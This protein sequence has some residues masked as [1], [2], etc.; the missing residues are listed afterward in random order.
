MAAL[1]HP[2]SRR[3]YSWWWDSHISPKN[4]KW[5]QENL[6]DMD[7][8]VKQMI[9]LLEEDADS[10]ARRAEMYY[11]KRPELMKLV[12][13]FYRA[14]RALAERYDHATG[15]LRQAHRT[16]AEAFP[17]QVPF[18]DSP[19]GSSASENDPQTPEMSPMIR[20]IFYPDE[21]QKDAL[22]LSPSAFNVFK[23]N[24]AF[25]EE[26]TVT[27]RK[28]LKEPN[29]SFGEGKARKG[30]NF[31]DEEEKEQSTQNNGSEHISA[32]VLSQSEQLGK[33]ETE[34]LTLKETLAKFEAEKEA[35]LLQYQQSLE[36]SS[37]LE[38]EVSSAHKDSKGFSQRASQAEAEVQTLKEAL[39]KLQSERDASVLQYQQCMEMISKL[40]DEV[41]HARKDAGELN[42]RATKTEVEAKAIRQDL[43]TVEAE[44]EAAHAQYNQ[45]LE[46]ISN[47]EEKLLHAEENARM[48]SERAD[49]A[50]TKVEILRQELARLTEEKEAAALQYL[51]CLETIAD[52]KHKISY[53]QEEA[54]RLT[55]E[56]DDGVVKLKGAEERCFLLEKSN[57]TLQSELESLVE[58]M[59][60]QSEELTEKQKELG[61]LWSCIQEERLRFVEAETAFQT[62]QHLHAESQEELR[63][64]GEELQNRTQIL[65]EME[66]CNQ[67]LEDEVQRAKEENKSLNELNLSSVVSIKN[68]QDEILSLRETIRK[69]EE[70]VE[71]R[72]DQRNA[73]QQEIY[74]LREELN[75]LN[76]KHLTVMDQ[77]ESVGYDSECFGSSVKDLQVEN[78]KLKEMCEAESSDKVLLLEKL[79]IVEK[80]LEK[81]VVL[82]NSLSDLHVELEGVKEKVKTLEESCQTLLG[83]KSA[84]VDEKATLIS[85]LQSTAANLE[86]LS[87]KNNFLENSLFD[88]N[89]E[90]EVLRIKSESLED[91]YMLL[92]M[93]KSG[94]V[95]ERESLFSQL[96][97]T[98]QR[99]EDLEKSFS[100]L[101]HKHSDLE[102][103]REC[104]LRKVEELQASL[105]AAQQEHASFSS[106]SEKRLASM[107]L[108]IHVLEEEGQCRKKEYEEQ[109]DK[110]FSAQIEIFILQKSVHDLEKKIVS[111]LIEC[112]NLLEASKLSGKLIS[113]LEH[114]NLEQQVKLKSLFGQM[115]NLRMGLYQV[116]KTL[117]I[118]ADH[119]FENKI[120][121]DEALLRHILSKLQETQNSI[122]RSYD[123]NQQLL[124][125]KSVL[126]TLLGQLKVDAVNVVTE[127]DNLAGEFKIRSE[128]FS[129]LQMEIQNLLGMNEKWRLK[130]MEGD[131]RIEELI[132][133]TENMRGQLMDLQRANQNLQEDYFKVLGEKKSVMKEAFDLVGE[134]SD[135]E[136]ANWVLFGEIMSQCNIS[137]IFNNMVTEKFA[138]LKELT[139]EL[140]K[141]RC[142]NNDLEEKERLMVGKLEDVQTE[143]LNLK[144]SLN[145]SE[146]EFASLKSISDQLRFEIA[147]G[148]DL[149]SRKENELL[150]AEQ[151]FGAT[152]NE[153]RQLH[154]LVEDLKDKY[155]EAKL[156]IKDQEKQILKLSANNDDQSKE[157][158]C[159]REVNQKL[160]SDLCRLCEEL[161]SATIR[162]ESLNSEMRKGTEEIKLWESQ[163]AAFFAELQISNVREVLFEGRIHDLAIACESLENRSNCK[164]TEIV[165]L[166]ERVSTLEGEKEGLEESLN[167]EMQKGTEEIKLWES[168][169]ATFLAELQISSVREVLFEGRIH[170]LAIACESLENRSNCKDTEIELL[171]DRVSTLEG[172]KEGLE[173]SFN[174][175]MRKGIEE[176][177]LWEGQAAAFFAELQISSVGEVLFEGRIH[178][179]TIAFES[180]ENWSNC[181][182]REIELLK[183]RVSTLEGEKEGLEESLNSEMRK[184]TEEIKLWESQAAAF[185]SELQISSV[186]EVLFEGRIHELTIACEGLENRSNCKDREIELLKERVSTLEGEKEG[187]E[188]SLNSEMRKGTEE[189]KLWESHAAA[190]FSEL[191]I[192]SVREVLFEGRI[193]ELT[194]ACEGLENRSNCKDT[195]IELLKEGVSTLE[196]EKEGLEESLNSEMQK[197]TEEIKLW[198]SQAAAFF[199]ELQI[200]SVREVLF[201]GRI[202][203]LTI[204]CESLENRSNCKDT[205][206]ELLKERVSTLEGENRGLQAHLA[207][208][209]PAVISVKHSVSS[210]EKHT[211]FHSRLSAVENE[212]AK[213]VL[214]VT[215]PH[216]EIYQHMD[217]NGITMVPDEFSDLQDLQRRVEAIEKAVVEMERLAMLEQLNA[218]GKLEAAM[219]EIEELKLQSHSRQENVQARK[220]VTPH[221]PEGKRVHGNGPS[222]GMQTREVS[223]ARNEVLTKDIMLDQ[224]SECSSYG[225]SRRETAEADQMLELWETT[226]RDGSIDP[227]VGKGQK[228]ATAQPH[229]QIEPVKEHKPARTPSE[230]LLE[231]ELAVD[232]L[233]ISGRL[234]EPR[235]R[236]NK[237]KILERLDS[238]AQKLTNL[239]ITVEDLKRKVENT[240]KSRKDKGVQCDTIK[241]QLG[242][243]EES[244]TKLFD[245]NRKLIKTV[246]SSSLSFDGVSALDSDES[247]NAR[248][249][250][251]DEAQRGSEK[252]GQLQLE[253]QKVQFLL[254]KLDDEK[255]TQGKT[256]ITDRKPKVL[257]RDYL[258]GG[259]RTNQKRKKTTFCAC[260]RP[261]TNGD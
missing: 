258:Y 37:A 169:A 229:N 149:L 8:K 124:I 150:E 125:E 101:E 173:E 200:S 120:N 40:E 23:R 174:S 177:K 184:G 116:L 232:K 69:L 81:N 104:S 88:A 146:N 251:S 136:E 211:L 34:I 227:M 82:E 92:D 218:N 86:K 16:M 256:R 45:C 156:I 97:V 178:E 189:I 100:E 215:R 135:L 207:A 181:K 78:S 142:I 242:E 64:L 196:G 213:D 110:T 42:E 228:G 226:D 5:L 257:L 127:R 158:G 137:L 188:E 185:F 44:K 57:Q 153:K 139:E 222:Q 221:Q 250:F 26:P 114:E 148:K 201:E 25:T 193:H 89:A 132:T 24:G 168:Q 14:Y 113:E 170:D 19:A 209:T 155:D 3:K 59:G 130:V 143:N 46:I 190:F 133:E 198:E 223:D 260:V 206:I 182:D 187:L 166:K 165:L 231:K 55:C 118:D 225:I 202:H 243:A 151:I 241:G 261:P 107:E 160:E 33:A 126:V 180:L 74:C 214:L 210:L 220:H 245:V 29:D 108:Q 106:S 111:L 252:I 224:I 105:D 85:Q 39:S 22:G 51:Q 102:N 4:S 71:L 144:E 75:E 12:E 191:Q 212:K 60:S 62:L 186:R 248:R 112:Q 48:T 90:L 9:K 152:A 80:L 50:E 217:E 122:S 32:Q 53:A 235:Q 49:K 237:R 175:E 147:H 61:R 68:L 47:L 129:E 192:S 123:E 77:V 161:R 17:N 259:L 163:A 115:K 103:E 7:A 28:T 246:E 172:E 73:L 31:Q 99:L 58:K 79:E 195:E 84:L 76:K 20:S 171:K 121:Q 87:E 145:E 238:D 36:K 27:S 162:E 91:S 109:Q 159:V 164:D 234:T 255:E 2:D 134:K 205:E 141:L 247:V 13:E 216:A 15:A 128:Q 98:K 249:K 43:V 203:E 66:T 30:L 219:R 54:Q 254:L 239:Q 233:E 1:S 119:M 63:S 183:E 236:G 93:E 154:K 35:V 67:G 157:M 117:E 38:S 65:K 41:S 176:I 199:A 18:D 179:L 21:L 6:T 167:S 83:D 131:H 140:D 240:E 253:V 94:L 138:E 204:A 72:V 70:E 96:D 11:K 197:G 230:S 10:F 194:I 208:Y 56:I 52:L 95:T 244:I